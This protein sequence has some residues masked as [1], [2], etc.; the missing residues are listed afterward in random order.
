MVAC[1]GQ[2]IPIYISSQE[3][4]VVNTFYYLWAL[5]E[6]LLCRLMNCGDLWK[7]WLIPHVYIKL[8][9]WD[10]VWVGSGMEKRF[11]CVPCIYFGGRCLAN[12]GLPMPVTIHRVTAIETWLRLNACV[13]ASCLKWMGF[14]FNWCCW[15]CG[16]WQVIKIIFVWI[17][18]NEKV[19]LYLLFFFC[20]QDSSHH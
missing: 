4:L 11:L 8:C 3:K 1:S 15:I 7:S 5:M 16:G 10:G 13:D 14:L 20:S 9:P 17:W 6:T 19:N 18:Q 12:P 2:A